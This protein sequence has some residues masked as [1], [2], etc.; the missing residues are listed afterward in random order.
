MIKLTKVESPL[1]PKLGDEN[2]VYVNS[3]TITFIETRVRE[4]APR[5]VCS[6]IYFGNS[7]TVLLVNEPASAIKN[8]IQT[9]LYT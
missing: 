2:I 1:G 4:S 5:G 3:L 6:A 7:G 9:G 8:M